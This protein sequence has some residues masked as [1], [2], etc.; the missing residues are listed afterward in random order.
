VGQI[1]SCAEKAH[2][3]WQHVWWCL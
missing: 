3:I 1:E 2:V